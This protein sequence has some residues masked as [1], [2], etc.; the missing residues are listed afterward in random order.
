MQTTF[1]FE[2]ASDIHCRSVDDSLGEVVSAEFA[3]AAR[4][5]RINR[6][7]RRRKDQSSIGFW[8]D[9]KSGYWVGEESAR[10]EEPEPGHP[11]RQRIAPVVEDRKNALLIR[12]PWLWLEELGENAE[13]VVATIQ[14]ALARAVESIYQLEEGEILVE[15]TP[16]RKNRR[17]LLFYEAA[18][19]G[20]GALSRLIQ[21]K[22]AF[23]RVAQKALSIMHYDSESFALAAE[24]GPDA[25]KPATETRCVAGCYRC[26]LSYFNQPDH[27]II[28]RRLAPVLTFLLRLAYADVTD[29]ANLHTTAHD[30]DNCPPH[31]TEPLDIGGFPIK[32]IWRASRV[33]A[34]DDAGSPVDLADLLASKGI[35]LVRLPGHSEER[36]AA[37]ARLASILEGKQP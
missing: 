17:A 2:K 14:H 28:D 32:W 21:E 35:D 7:L 10:D 19:G 12:F 33:A 8:I 11:R 1:S 24:Q 13:S 30:L 4:V 18:E 9:P 26:L 3:P 20:A 6:G 15:P 22:A 16:N 37:V 27:E 29:V 5:R 31:D 36:I 23:G 34:V 25:L